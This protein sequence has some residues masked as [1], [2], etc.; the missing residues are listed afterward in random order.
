[1]DG[2]HVLPAHGTGAP[3]LHTI[4][5]APYG[6]DESEMEKTAA[7]SKIMG[8]DGREWGWMEE[9]AVEWKRVECNGREWDDMEDNGEAASSS[10]LCYQVVNLPLL[11]LMATMQVCGDRAQIE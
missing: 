7:R 5:Q 4:P 2:V 10:S 8:W 6:L 1:M 3:E 11:E 9:S